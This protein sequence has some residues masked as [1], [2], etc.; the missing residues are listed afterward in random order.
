MRF[1][2][3]TWEKWD[4][5]IPHSSELPIESTADSA[6]GALIAHGNHKG[7]AVHSPTPSHS[8]RY[9]SVDFGLV[10]LVALSLNG[11]NGCDTCTTV[12]NAAQLAWLKEDLAKVDRKKTPWVIATSHFPLYLSQE[13]LEGALAEKPL[14]QQ[15]W[16]AAEECEFEGHSHNCTGGKDWKPPALNTSANTALQDLE[17]VFYEF[18]VRSLSVVLYT[19]FQ[20]RTLHIPGGYLLGRPHPPLRKIPLFRSASLFSLSNVAHSRRRSMGPSRKEKS[21]ATAHTTLLA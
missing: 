9:F 8:S 7:P 15:A 19:C 18:G 1:L 2:D 5:S 14:S 6:L 21:S 12:C 3:Q 10:H 20:L 11:Y 4:A 17:P 16:F 13:D